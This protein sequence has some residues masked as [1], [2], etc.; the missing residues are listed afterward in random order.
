M[1][2]VERALSSTPAFFQKL[3]NIGLALAAIS[4]PLLL[5]LLRCRQSW[6]RLQAISLL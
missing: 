4:T 2:V 1:N 3:R 5:H 6:L